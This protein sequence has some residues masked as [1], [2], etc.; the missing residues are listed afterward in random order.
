MTFRQRRILNATIFHIIVGA[1]GFCMVYPILW[2]IA[3]SFESNSV[4]FT[5][6]QI[7]LIPTVPTF[8]NYSNGMRGFG[9]AASRIPFSVFF[10]NSFI[11]V[12]SSTIGQVFSSALVAYGFARCRF[13]FKKMLFGCVIVTLMLPAQILAIPQ[14]IMFQSFGW[15]NTWL[16]LIVPAFFG[17]PFFIFMIFQFIQNI[18]RDLD[19]AAYIDGCSKY[20]IFFRIILPMIVPALVTSGI[21]AFYWR[22][23]DFFQPLL[24]IQSTRLYPVSMALKMFADPGASSDWGAL[25]AMSVLSLLPVMVLFFSFQKYL[26]EGISTTGL[27]G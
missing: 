27:K 10:R 9:G 23:D 8:E 17:F 14:Y 16:P 26:V 13:R 6:N 21:F 25:Y 2:M 18:P 20:T 7:S 12:I 4:M 1:L 19:E 3:S 5:R 11:I 15:V 22:W 24:Y